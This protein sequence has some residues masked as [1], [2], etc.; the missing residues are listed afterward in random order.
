MN[1][2]RRTEIA[3][4]ATALFIDVIDEL[5][6]QCRERQIEVKGD[7]QHGTSAEI[8]RSAAIL[9]DGGASEKTEGEGK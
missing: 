6:R 3:S 5:D 7:E 8:P 4:F 1:K 2:Y 9:D